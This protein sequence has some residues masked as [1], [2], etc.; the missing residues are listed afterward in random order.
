MKFLIQRIRKVF[1][2]IKNPNLIK[3]I[4]RLG[5]EGL[6]GGARVTDFFFFF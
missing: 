4:W 5:G 3:K 1:F 2:F 6:G